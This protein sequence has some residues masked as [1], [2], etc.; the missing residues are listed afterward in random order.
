M[1]NLQIQ[2]KAKAW[3]K[4]SAR[5]EKWMLSA[6]RGSRDSIVYESE[7]RAIR[8]CAFDLLASVKKWKKK[9]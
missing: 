8:F 1:T 2:R 7:A 3:L 4:I 9:P 5:F 6:K